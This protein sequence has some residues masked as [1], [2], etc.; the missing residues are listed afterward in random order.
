MVFHFRSPANIRLPAMIAMNRRSLLRAAAAASAGLVLIM[1][2]TYLTG[3]I[4]HASDAR[5]PARTRAAGHHR[6][7]F[8]YDEGLMTV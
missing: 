6:E 5:E 8:G 2:R 7:Y 3:S 4:S 1:V